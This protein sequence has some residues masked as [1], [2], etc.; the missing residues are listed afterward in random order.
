M[1]ASL[2][3]PV[4]LDAPWHAPDAGAQTLPLPPKSSAQTSNGAP[5]KFPESES[6]LGLR[7]S[8]SIAHVLAQ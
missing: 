3:A 6:R 5:M 7:Q 4:S 1:P 2:A 8:P